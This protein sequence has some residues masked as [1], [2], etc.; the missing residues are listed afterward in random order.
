MKIWS[1]AGMRKFVGIDRFTALRFGSLFTALTL[2]AGCGSSSSPGSTGTAPSVQLKGKVFGGQFPVAGAD[3]QL[4]AVG[5]SGYGVGAQSLL[6]QPVSSDENGNFNI[7]SAEYA[8]PSSSTLTYLVATGGD[9]GVGSDNSAIAL[10]APLGTCSSISTDSFV[11]INEVTTVAAAWALAP[12]TGPGA[13]IGTSSTNTQGLANAF[14]NVNN[15]VNIAQGTSPGSSPP[16]GAVIPTTK[17]NTLANILASCVNSAGT[18]ACNALF[19]PATPVN[20]SAPTN[21]FDAAVDIARN[22]ANNVSTLFSLPAPTAP[23]A[24]VLTAAPHDWSIAITYTGGGLK[25][26]ASIALD[27]FGNLWAAN[28][29]GSSTPCS[30]ITE[31]SSTGQPI[32]SSSGFTDGSLWESFGIAIDSGADCWVTNEQ[33]ASV[34]GGHGSLSILNSV[35]TIISSA[36]G[37]YGGGV[38][39][40]VALAID[41]DGS[42]WTANQGDSTASLFSNNGSALSSSTGW[43]AGVLAGPSAVAIDSSHNAWFADQEAD[44][45]SVT[46]ISHD[47]SQ[48]TSFA[49]GGEETTGIATDAI[50]NSSTNVIGHVWTTNYSTSTVS[51][52]ELMNNG[53][54]SVVSTGLSG[55]GLN[56]PD[57]IA[58]DGAGNIWVANHGGNT[59]TELQGVNG[60]S[61][62]EPLSPVVG[63]G[64]D[65]NLREPYGVAIDAS[66][67]VWISNFGLSTITQ[68]IGAA[69][70]V[71][72]PLI[73]PPQ[74]P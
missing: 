43:G 55:G 21:T 31:L 68:L 28:Y 63:F 72:T 37:Y 19:V 61:P 65:A 45:G 29:C 20:G 8:C 74:L 1:S 64:T 7:T 52:L 38:D 62:G 73:G 24:P 14:A 23:F 50:S 56:H 40:P 3:I 4:Y 16:A 15:I 70:P 17:I 54:V 36:G 39:F 13:Q 32:S 11:Q 48:A 22:P 44:S 53:S 58:V 71:K 6:T 66:G 69:S 57:G 46:S 67:D 9:P 49:S 18:S 47:G 12:F 25:Y 41:T 26:P 60:A 5:S 35:G 2:I 27:N 34:N 10:V 30:S 59:I 51:E 42:V 33:T